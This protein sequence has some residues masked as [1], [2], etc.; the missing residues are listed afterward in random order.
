[1]ALRPEGDSVDWSRCS[2][3]PIIRC[4]IL[5]IRRNRGSEGAS[6]AIDRVRRGERVWGGGFTLGAFVV[7][8]S[9]HVFTVFWYQMLKAEG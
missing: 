6:R 7:G 1:M 9:R 4:H 5:M 2:N 8:S 3:H